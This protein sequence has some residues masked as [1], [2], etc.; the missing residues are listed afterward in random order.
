MPSSA[1]ASTG[2]TNIGLIVGVTIGAVA[3]VA[4]VVGA[5]VF[6]KK[7]RGAGNTGSTISSLRDSLAN[8]GDGGDVDS[9]DFL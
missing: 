5:A 4:L 3:L 9:G 2:E 1:A 6:L 8:G 7:R